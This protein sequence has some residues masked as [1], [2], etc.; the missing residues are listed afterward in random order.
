[1][2]RTWISFIILSVF[3]LWISGC[4]DDIS[5]GL[6]D[7]SVSFSDNGEE[8]S[9]TFDVDQ[10]I[11]K[12]GTAGPPPTAPVIEDFTDVFANITIDVEEGMPGIT[13]NSYTISYQPMETVDLLGSTV[14]PPPI[15]SL[16]GD[17]QGSTHYYIGTG[18]TGTFPI[19][20]M[21]IQQKNNFNYQTSLDIYD[22]N[23]NLTPDSEPDGFPDGDG[24]VDPPYTYISNFR[25]TIIITLHCTD[26]N[27]YNRDLEIRRTIY[28]GSYDNC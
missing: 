13:V 21:S 16:D 22:I 8:G 9:L 25:C 4:G 6:Y 17:L 24:I 3:C 15:A 18:S 27:G 28:L 12:A 10:R 5:G 26:D 20:C 2:K 1:M 7:T 19:T 14:T 23:G 11:C